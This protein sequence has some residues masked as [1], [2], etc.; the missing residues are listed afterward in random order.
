MGDL[1]IILIRDNFIPICLY[2]TIQNAI[3]NEQIKSE[4]RRNSKIIIIGNLLLIDNN[5]FL[6]FNQ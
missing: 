3:L 6:R 5:T 1:A 4:K 2:A